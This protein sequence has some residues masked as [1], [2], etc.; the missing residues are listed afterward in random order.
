MLHGRMRIKQ[1]GDKH[2]KVVMETRG[3]SLQR[4]WEPRL[5]GAVAGMRRVSAAKGVG[6]QGD[7]W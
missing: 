2:R 4:G 7:Q 5:R 6:T 1:K 3:V